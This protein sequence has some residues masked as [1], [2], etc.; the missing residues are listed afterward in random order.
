M[1]CKI[2][3]KPAVSCYDD[4]M[5][6]DFF[7]CPLCEFIFKDEN[8]HVSEE[9]E[10]QQ[11]KNHNNSFDSPGYVQMFRDFIDTTI[12]PYKQEIHTALEFGSGPGPVLTEL[13]KQEGFEVDMYDKFFSP[14]K[15][16][17][18]KTYDL[19]TSTEVIEHIG[20]PLVHMLRNSIEQ[21]IES[22]EKRAITD[23][24]ATDTVELCLSLSRMKQRSLL[25]RNRNRNR[26][27]DT[28]TSEYCRY[29]NFCQTNEENKWVCL[30]QLLV[31]LFHTT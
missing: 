25:Y 1:H 21:G 10:L 29:R 9:H 13:L 6:S 4:V 23:K 20:D 30:L 7:H 19:I 5:Q 11:Y 24:S 27:R 8:S 17:E 22:P 18:D 15:I 26:N 31:G 14:E 28:H 16:Y 3:S 2:C 12:H